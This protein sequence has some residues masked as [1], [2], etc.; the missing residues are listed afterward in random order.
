[1]ATPQ[2]IFKIIKSAKL[3]AKEKAQLMK[4]LSEVDDEPQS[5]GAEFLTQHQ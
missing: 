3:S 2:E 1:M 5:E 4:A